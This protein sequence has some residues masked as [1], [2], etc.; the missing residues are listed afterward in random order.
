MT[1]RESF[2]GAAVLIRDTQ[3]QTFPV[4]WD[5][6]KI[7]R[8][9]VRVDHI[10]LDT[11]KLKLASGIIQSSC[12]VSVAVKPVPSFICMPVIQKIVVQKSSADK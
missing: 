10:L 3:D 4:V 8:E 2:K 5:M 1:L 9:H 7:Q 6:R 12:G 11:V